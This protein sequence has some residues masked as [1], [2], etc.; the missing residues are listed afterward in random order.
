[1]NK[2]VKKGLV[3][4]CLMGSANAFAAGCTDA[5]LAAWSDVRE[6]VAGTLE[7]VAPGLEASACALQVQATA[8][9]ADRARVQDQT[10]ACE[11]SYRA[12]FVYDLSALGQLASAERTKVYNAQCT[13][14]GQGFTCSNTGVI[15]FKLKGDNSGVGNIY[16]SFVI[17]EGVANADNRRKFDIPVSMAGPEAVEFQWVRASSAGA[18]DGIFRVWWGGNTTEAS[19]DLEYT[20]LDNFDNCITQT[21]M[22]NIKANAT[23]AAGKNGVNM[24]FDEFESRRQTGIG[25]N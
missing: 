2:L 25:V 3:L 24:I 13:D 14:E 6:D 11:N 22:G 19:P 12:R 15:Q 18:S 17:D 23:F 9:D 7:V 5:N 8:S 21:N 20:D 10:A 16:R 4:A 1:M